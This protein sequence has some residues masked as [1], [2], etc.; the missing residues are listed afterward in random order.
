MSTR[1]GWRAPGPFGGL[2]HAASV[3][4]GRVNASRVEPAE[5]AMA[6]APLD[7]ADFHDYIDGCQGE[8]RAL[9]KYRALKGSK[10]FA[11]EPC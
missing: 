4:A 2:G 3:Q 9:D 1:P 7:E 11:S 8:C 6:M 5:K 10:F